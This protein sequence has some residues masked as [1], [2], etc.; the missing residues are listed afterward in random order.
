M[1]LVLFKISYDHPRFVNMD[2]KVVILQNRVVNPRAVVAS[3]L[4]VMAAYTV[5]AFWLSFLVSFDG[6]WQVS[7]RLQL[8]SQGLN[9][10]LSFERECSAF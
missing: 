7:T 4:T 2:A 10:D 8:A 9:L 3:A 6:R 1:I 5:S